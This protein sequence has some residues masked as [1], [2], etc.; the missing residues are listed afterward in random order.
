M[1]RYLGIDYGKKRIGL[2]LSDIMGMMSQPFDVI[3]FKGLQNNIQNILKIAKEKE[4]SCIVV[5]KP[6]NMN[7]TEGEMAQLAT[8]FVE[9]LKKVTDIKVEMIDERLTTTQ[10]ERVLVEEANVSREK[11]K[12]LRDKLAATFILQTY[13]DI[14]SKTF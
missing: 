11:R 4:V 6:V 12:G 8:E 5:G 7:G 10:A 2:A 14:Y 3:E 1:G 9:E 13:L